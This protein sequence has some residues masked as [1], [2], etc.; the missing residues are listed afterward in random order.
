[1][2]PLERSGGGCFWRGRRLHRAVV[3]V[4]G[5]TRRGVWEY[6]VAIP[7]IRARDSAPWSRELLHTRTRRVVAIWF[8]Y[9]L[10]LV[11]VPV[12]SRKKTICLR[13]ATARC[14]SSNSSSLRK[15][16]FVWELLHTR[17]RRLVAIQVPSR[18]KTFFSGRAGRGRHVGSGQ[19]VKG[20]RVRRSESGDLVM[21]PYLYRVRPNPI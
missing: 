10:S 7:E 11:A 6:L 15:K 8:P 13:I 16:R 5:N 18:K 12:P 3:E 21:S 9:P 19:Y 4:R 1:M 20:W 14:P 17:A 2:R